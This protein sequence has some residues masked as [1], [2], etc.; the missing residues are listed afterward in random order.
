MQDQPLKLIGLVAAALGGNPAATAVQDWID[1]VSELQADGPE[2]A[3]ATY[4]GDP[5]AGVCADP[6]GGD[7]AKVGG[8]IR[9]LPPPEARPFV[10]LTCALTPITASSTSA[11]PGPLVRAVVEC[12]LLRRGGAGGAPAPPKAIPTGMPR[13]TWF[14]CERIILFWSAGW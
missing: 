3:G 9:S 12:S 1:A 10:T 14:A 11:V 4:G 8:L 2:A 5:T 6:Q 7:C 13:S